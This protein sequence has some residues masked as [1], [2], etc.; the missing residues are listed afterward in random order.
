ML[1]NRY[2]LTVALM[3]VSFAAF[4]PGC[5]LPD[6]GVSLNATP[7]ALDFGIDE[8]LLS[9][10]VTMNPSN[11]PLTNPIRV[12][13][14]KPWIIPLDCTSNSDG[15]FIESPLDIVV[16]P[17]RIDRSLL[18]I[19]ENVGKITLRTGTASDL[20]IEISVEDTL[21]ADFNVD[22]QVPEVGE[23]VRF[24]DA[25]H[26]TESAG[27]V[28]SRLWSFGDGA[29]SAATNPVHAY[30]NSGFYTVSLTVSTVN[31]EETRVRPALISVGST[32]IGVN[33]VA[34]S[35]TVFESDAVTFTDI[36]NLNLPV[37]S[38]LWDFGVTGND[39]SDQSTE[40][41]PVFRYAEAGIYTVS[42]TV[43][44]SAGDVTETKEEY[45]LVQSKVAPMADF[46]IV[47]G[48]VFPAGEEIQF[49]DRSQAG[50]AP[51][52]WLWNFG[53][54]NTSEDQN[55]TH[56]FETGGVFDVS[57]TVVSDHGVNTKTRPVTILVT[58]PTA[59]FSIVG[60]EA[61]FGTETS[62][63]NESVLGTGANPT[64]LWNFGDG[65]TSTDPNPTHTYNNLGIFSISLTVTTTHGSD[66][67]TQEFNI[68]FAPPTAVID[69]ADSAETNQPVAFADTG[70]TGGTAA[71]NEWLWDFG[72]GNTSM[73]QN[74]VHVYAA[75]G[76]YTVSLTVTTLLA[77]NNTD[78]TA[79]QITIVNPPL[80]AF[81]VDSLSIVTTVPVQFI[82]RTTPGT[83]TQILYAW[84]F[85]NGGTSTAANPSFQFA[86]P[87]RYTV[88]LT[89]MS[90]SSAPHSVS[91]VLTVDLPPSPNFSGTPRTLFTGDT[92]QFTDDSDDEG[93]RPITARVWRFGD[94]SISTNI[95]PPH[96]YQAAGQYTVSLDLQFRH[97]ATG[98]TLS[99]TRTR[100]NYIRV[101]DRELTVGTNTDIIDGDTSSVFALAANPGDDGRVSLRE[102]ITAANNTPGAD[103]I[104]FEGSV[105]I[106]V[107][108]ALPPLTDLSGGVTIN[109][110]LGVLDG[111]ALLGGENGIE[112]NSAGNVIDGLKIINFPGSGIE[113]AGIAANDNLIGALGG[114]AIG[115]FI[116]ANGAYGI[117]IT[118]PEPARNQ[119][120]G[121]SI[122]ANGDVGIFI[123]DGGNQGIAAPVITAIEPV[124]GTVEPNATI[125]IF[126]GPDEEGESIFET[127]IAD[128]AGNFTGTLSL[129]LFVPFLP[130]NVTATA[131]DAAGNTSEFSA[132]FAVPA[133]LPPFE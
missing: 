71:I 62:F 95:N 72:D 91:S 78:T 96:I 11:T 80:P 39:T 36:S 76:V 49:I 119:I 13:A 63:Q 94:A 3:V 128:A 32:E 86:A 97:S 115:N 51:I 85:G 17:V 37:I 83:E 26:T 120:R 132:P 66:T 58:A 90:A 109:G 70:S 112:I 77:S 103:T 111:S 79:K 52:Q 44:T 16:I 82:N 84:D 69:S 12:I 107:T 110:G 104:S 56:T 50:T 57:L 67:A 43:S 34:S 29:T 20:V 87:G 99:T 31:S 88:T 126:I 75:P 46:S 1:S 98:E 53:D 114:N 7:G 47:G 102:A 28:I 30:Q 125:E 22:N 5:T 41:S 2:V 54:G 130:V 116:T 60:G 123:P 4:V 101:V 27:P 24:T 40:E 35:T 15:C 133:T 113:I 8:D 10:V 108:S 117:K 55:P 64:Y 106:L 89:A 105:S 18:S 73:F 14:N 25:S 9:I 81:E 124:R 121:N 127:V 23:A 118:G 21:E 45:I 68:D 33:F 131:T 129:D 122:F 19:G 100:N 59:A 48:T 74:P 61:Y 42:L 92:V 93:A 65:N 38:R 6:V